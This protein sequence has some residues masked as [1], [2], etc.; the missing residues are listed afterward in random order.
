M[1]YQSLSP[2]VLAQLTAALP[3][4]VLSGDQLTEDYAHDE[5]I[6]AGSVCRTP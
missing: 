4:S 3:G 2:E 6:S 5:M 1:A